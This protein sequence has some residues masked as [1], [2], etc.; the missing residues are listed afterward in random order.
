MKNFLFVLAVLL[1]ISIAVAGESLA[2]GYNEKI[3]WKDLKDGFEEAKKDDK[4]IMM[5]MVKSACEACDLLKDVFV[6]S[7]K[8]FEHSQ[9]FVMVHLLDSEIPPNGPDSKFHPDL[10]DYAP[11]I[12]F[13]DPDGEIRKDIFNAI[14]NPEY[15]YYYFREDQIV[16]AMKAILEDTPVPDTVPVTEGKCSSPPADKDEL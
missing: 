6:K 4:P 10:M 15:K 8:I 12:I 7:Q 9:D 16:N 13:A 3:A 2:R 1:S 5:L 11:K 14:G